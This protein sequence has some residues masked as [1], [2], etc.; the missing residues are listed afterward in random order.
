MFRTA[1]NADQVSQGE[2]KQEGGEAAVRG[3]SGAQQERP[4][5]GAQEAELEGGSLSEQ[6]E[7]KERGW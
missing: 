6:G 7:E 1:V 4:L 3:G 2:S 5:G